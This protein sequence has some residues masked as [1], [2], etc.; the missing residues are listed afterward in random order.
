MNDTSEKLASSKDY[1]KYQAESDLRT[2]TEAKR[3]QADPKRMAHVRHCAK[4]K[5]AEMADLKKLATG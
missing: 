1:D 2:I 3:I 5:L 4:D